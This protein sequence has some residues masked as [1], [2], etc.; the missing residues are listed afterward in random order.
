MH[1][2]VEIKLYGTSTATALGISHTERD[3]GVLGPITRKLIKAKLI[4][5]ETLVA[6]T[7]DG[8]PVFAP[9]PASQYSEWDVYEFDIGIKRRRYRSFPIQTKQAA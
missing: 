1:N 4:T 2:S 9:V 7:R 8:S 3:K 5:E 6:V